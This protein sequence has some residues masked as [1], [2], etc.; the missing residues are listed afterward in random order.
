MS[1]AVRQ[2]LATAANTVDGVD[3]SA[4]FKQNARP[5][6]GSVRFGLET[7]PNPFGGLITWQVLVNLPQDLAEAEEWIDGHRAALVAALQP[8]LIV[9]RVLTQQLVLAKDRTQ[10]VLVVEGIREE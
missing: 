6:A 10:P 7:Y 2:A 4:Y 1:A 3:V 9:Q 8:E 5:G